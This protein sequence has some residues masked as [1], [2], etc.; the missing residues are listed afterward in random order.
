MRKLLLAVLGLGAALAQE[1]NPQGIIVNPVPTDLEVRVWVDKDPAKRGN[2]VY[3]IGESI[4]IYVRV[5]QDAYVYLFNINADG[6][7]DPILPNPYER[8]NFLRAG[9]TR[10]FPPEGVRYRYT[11]TGPEGE[12]RI[13]AVASRRPLSV[14]EILDVERGE[15]RVQGWEGLARALSIVIKPVPA[16]DWVTD[17]ARYYVGRGEAPPPAEATLEVDSS[18]RG[19]EVYVDGRREGKTPLSL[20]VRPGRHEVE[21]RLP[22]YAPYRATVNARPGERVRVFAR[23]VPEPKKEGVLSVASSPQGAEV[24]VDGALRGR[25][26]LALRLPEGRYQ[27]ELRLPGYAPYRVEV[28]VREGERAQVFARL[29]PLPRE[30]TLVLEARP[31]GAEVYVDGRLVGRAPLSL[32]LEAGLHEVRLLAPGYAEYRARV[33][34]RPEETLRLSVELVPLR[35]TLEVYVNVEARVFLDGEEV[36]RTR[37]GYLR[38][39]VPFGEHELTLV[40]PGYRTLVQTLHVSRDRVLRFQ[41]VPLGR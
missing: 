4:Y 15:V 24:Y 34:V 22:G 23:L 20:A 36:G 9:E 6:R 7:I 12:D 19:A 33:E 27:V 29:V 35:A 16:K 30:G 11:I 5:N 8:D 18:P 38:L 10:R 2:A 21:L 25:T 26:P 17:V 28:R 13:L 1:I 14:A 41:M 32:S 31:E 39:E 40:A 37:G 3:R